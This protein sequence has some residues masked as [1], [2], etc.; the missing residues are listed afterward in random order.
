[1][2]NPP[3]IFLVVRDPQL[4]NQARGRRSYKDV[5]DA[6]ECAAATVCLLATGKRERVTADLAGRI[7]DALDVPRGTLF[8]LSADDHVR[9]QPYSPHAQAS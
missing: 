7:E 1:M 6:A 9:L 2:A 8:A 4:L 5:A 3:G